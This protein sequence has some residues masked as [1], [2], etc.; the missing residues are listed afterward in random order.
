MKVT[1][2]EYEVDIKAKIKKSSGDGYYDYSEDVAAGFFLNDVSS[3]ISELSK[4]ATMSHDI[5]E[6]LDE[7]G[8]YKREDRDK[9]LQQ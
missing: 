8:F 2:G 3:K 5:Y 9:W 1:I 7:A 6:G 4:S